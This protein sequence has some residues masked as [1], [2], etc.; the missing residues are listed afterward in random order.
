[1]SHYYKITK[2]PKT[3]KFEKAAWL[4]MGKFYYVVFSDRCWYHEKYSIWEFQ[5]EDATAI[6]EKPMLQKLHN[7]TE[8]D[9]N[10]SPLCP[11]QNLSYQLRVPPLWPVG[12]LRDR[13]PAA[14]TPLRKMS[15]AFR[16]RD[17]VY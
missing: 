12:N 13:Q 11:H 15:E 3:G 2:H 10:Y 7:S 14:C 16:F 6:E 17:R 4:D 5:E 9:E 1:M 8:Y